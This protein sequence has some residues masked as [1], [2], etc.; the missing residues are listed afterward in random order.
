MVPSRYVVI[1]WLGWVQRESTPARYP[2][3]ALLSSFSHSF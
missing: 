1:E 2:T 3:R